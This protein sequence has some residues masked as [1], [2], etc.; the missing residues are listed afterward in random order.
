V[1]E[2]AVRKD[3]E[4]RYLVEH[5]RARRLESFDKLPRRAEEGG[6]DPDAIEEADR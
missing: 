1:T 3:A 4:L 5:E 6:L 2:T